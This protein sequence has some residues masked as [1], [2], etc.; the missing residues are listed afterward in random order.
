MVVMNYKGINEGLTRR[1]RTRSVSVALISIVTSG[2]GSLYRG[3][4][5]VK[6]INGNTDVG[7]LVRT[8]I[9]A[10]S[11]LVTI[12]TSSRLGLLYYLVTRGTGRYRAVTHIHGPVC[13]GRVKFV[14]RHL[15]IAVVVGP[16]FTTTRRVS[17]LLHF[18]STVGV[19][20]FTHNHMR[21]L[22]FGILPRFGLSKVDIS[23]VSS[24][25]QD[26]VLIYT[27]RDHSGMSVPNN[28]RVVRSKSVISVLTSPLGT[29]TFF[30]GVNLGA[31]RIGG[32]VVMNNKAV[33]CC[34]TRTLLSVGVD[35]G[36]VRR[37]GGHYRR[38]DRL[39]PSTAV[40]GNSKAGHSLL[41]RRK[42]SRSRSFIALAGLSRR[43]MFLTLFT[44]DVSSTGLITGIG[45]LRFSSIVSSL[46]VKDIV[47]PGGVATSC[48]LRC[49][50]TA[51]G[52]VNDGMR[53]LCRV[54]S[55]GTRTLRFTVHRR[56]TMACVPLTRLGL[57]GGL[58]IKYLGHGNHVHVPHNRSAVRMNSAIVVMAA[59][60][61]LHSVAS[62]LTG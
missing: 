34:L 54:L 25:F 48:V 4:S 26:S 42:L 59:R 39:L 60:G 27:V 1:L 35:I 56:S 41:L 2:V 13:R 23:R 57:H 44:G 11:V 18:P 61:N 40:V 55:N 58:L 53:A 30:H 3:V 46:S 7:A 15:N 14:G 22:G 29:T 50:H 28:S 38:L 9:S 24:T 20:A 12:A 31:G 16:R 32:Y 8:N 21:L 45:H 33:S 36:V 49:I 51:R 52:D 10:T 43:G 47:C 5:T 17:Q 6:V 19:S 37:G 62:V